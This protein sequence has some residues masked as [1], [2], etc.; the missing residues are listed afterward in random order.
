MSMNVVITNDA[1][2]IAGGENYAL[3]LAEGLR[4]RNH[5]VIIAPLKNSALAGEARERKFLVYEIPYGLKGREFNAVKVLYNYLRKEKID[6]VHSNSNLDRTIAAFAGK[7]I[8]AKNFTTVHSCL[9][10]SRNV[11]HR[12]RNKFLIARFTPVGFSTKDILINMDLIPEEKISVV[13]IGLPPAQF[14]YSSEGRRKIRNEFSIKDEEILIG[15]VSRLVEFKGHSNLINAFKDVSLKNQKLKLLI[16][17]TGE[18]E[19]KLKKQTA[20][21]QLEDKI[22]FTGNRKDISD[23]LSAIDIFAQTSIDNGGE[24]FP[25]SILEAISVGLPIIAS[26]VGD[27]KYLVRNENGILLQPGNVL[28]IS[29]SILKLS[30]NQSLIEKY[31]SASRKLFENEYTVGRMVNK[32]ESLYLEV[33]KKDVH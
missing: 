4:E 14:V 7:F 9:S 31:K 24:T 33:L 17:G 19:T 25:V 5:K 15:T 32:I 6:I 16:V 2:N 3:Y 28:Q 23:I 13:H 18:L 29:D 21:L 27:I 22:I 26:N 20:N 1:V 10:I 8:G 12:F 11:T 30:S